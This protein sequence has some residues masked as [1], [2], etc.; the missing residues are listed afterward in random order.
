MTCAFTSECTHVFHQN[1]TVC[2][3]Y[4][5]TR[6]HPCFHPRMDLCFHLRMELYFHP[7]MDWYFHST[8][9]EHAGSTG[10]LGTV[11]MKGRNACLKFKLLDIWYFLYNGFLGFKVYFLLEKFWTSSNLK[12]C[13]GL[14]KSTRRPVIFVCI[15]LVSNF[16][17]CWKSTGHPVI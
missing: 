14:F 7:R 2:Y 13:L 9:S 17:F 4:F 11:G 6:M 16:T 8:N 12:G 1:G 15:T 10:R 3:P 5:N